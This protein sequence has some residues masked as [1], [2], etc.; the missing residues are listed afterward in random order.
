MAIIAFGF[1]T[2]GL[3]VGRYLNRKNQ[4]PE[5]DAFV[6]DL[7]SLAQTGISKREQEVL[8][9]LA[10]GYSNQEIAD[11]L[12]VSLN[13]IKTHL[14]NV[15]SKLDVKRRTQAVVRAKELRLIS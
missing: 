6:P 12:F 2:A 15:Y 10:Q 14:N 1:L 11:K 4:Q 8:E 7:N 13:T 9:C 3:Y 5:L